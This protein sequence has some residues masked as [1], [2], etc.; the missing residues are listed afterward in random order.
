[1]VVM[2]VVMV[3]G[4]LLFL[5]IAGLVTIFIA[6]E[7]LDLTTRYEKFLTKKFKEW[8]WKND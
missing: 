1:M 4:A 3:V 2:L 5:G 6:E 7:Q 8:G